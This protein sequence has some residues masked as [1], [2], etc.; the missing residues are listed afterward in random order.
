[1][2]FA[3]SQS[4]DWA[5]DAIWYQIFPERFCNG[6]E[7]N[8]QTVESL[9]GTW[10]YETPKNWSVSPWTSDCYE[11]QN[12]EAENKRGF[13]YNA[14]LRRYGG[15]IQGIIDKLDYLENLGITA[16]YLNP[17]FESPSAHKY[18][19]AS[20]HHIDKHFG[21]NPAS[22]VQMV[23]HENPNEPSSWQWTSADLLFLELVEKVHQRGMKIIIDGVFNHTGIP[24]WALEDVRK[25]GENSEFSDW[26]TIKSYDNPA[27]ETD[28]FSYECWFGIADL[29]ELREDENGLIAPI[30][31][32]IFEAVKR[33][34]D[35][36][37]DGNPDDGIDGWRLDVADMVER[38]FWSDFRDFT[39]SINPECY[40]VGEVWWKDYMKNIQHNAAHWLGNDGFDAVMNYRFGDAVFKFFNDEKKQI[41]AKKFDKMLK[42]I[43]TDYG[44]ERLFF[45]QN[46]LDSHDLERLASTVVNPDRWMDHASNLQYDPQ[47]KTRKPNEFEL[48]KQKLILAF[49]FT[50]LGAPFI[51]YGDEIG[52]WGAD[53]PDCRKPMIWTE[54]NY[55]D[56]KMLP[57]G[58]MKIAEKVAVN[59][60][61]LEF[62][63]SLIQLRKDF[64]SLRRGSYQTIL[65]DNK[66][67]LFAF[68]RKFEGERVVAVFNAS[69]DEQTIPNSIFDENW[70]V[71]FGGKGDILESK[72]AKV[73]LATK[74]QN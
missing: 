29:P 38:K 6:D 50:F 8:D 40:L 72:S 42:K 33:W 46:M 64:I 67:K 55:A 14:Q 28:E 39:K 32:H 36:N 19:C 12:W 70:L 35:P 62:Y 9:R 58:K 53:D 17:I 2:T 27:T 37:G 11:L 57:S 61:L 47:F 15:D 41:S 4:P 49:Q 69:M 74:G 10:P 45:L 71:I 16:I 7:T 48:Q 73:F 60:E 44:T 30:K 59:A 22:D 68:E 18:G 20:Y 63:Q 24:F 65:A 5:K 13:Y 1:M 43:K 66:T 21:P 52:M 51:Y 54:L 3:F 25:N 34:M 26:F 23:L 56:E 31:S